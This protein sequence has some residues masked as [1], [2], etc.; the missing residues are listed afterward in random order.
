MLSL[1]RLG[2]SGLILGLNKFLYDTNL[3]IT[4]FES[5]QKGLKNLSL[6]LSLCQSKS[7]T[8]FV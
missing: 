6:S 7:F 5:G 3:Y 2:C 4:H 8:Y 1:V